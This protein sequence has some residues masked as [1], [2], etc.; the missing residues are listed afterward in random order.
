MTVQAV[1][2]R[3]WSEIQIVGFLMHR[4]I[5]FCRLLLVQE[6]E[7]LLRELR[8]IDLK[9]RSEEEID[10]VNQ[11]ISKLGVDLNHAKEFS[12]KQIADRY[13]ITEYIKTGGRS[14]PR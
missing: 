4:L 2:C 14:E 10:N 8:S 9:N 6:K 13:V 11:R 7:Q 3:T 5:L 12:N 1:L